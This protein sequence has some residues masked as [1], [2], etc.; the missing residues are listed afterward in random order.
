[1]CVDEP[2]I[3]IFCLQKDYLLDDSELHFIVNI[4]KNLVFVLGGEVA[5]EYFSI[6]HIK[7]FFHRLFWL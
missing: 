5:K 1:M 2:E 6:L 7:Y 4:N 3:L